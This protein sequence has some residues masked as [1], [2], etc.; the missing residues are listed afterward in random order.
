MKDYTR[1]RI[2]HYGYKGP[3]VPNDDE[4]PDSGDGQKMLSGVAKSTGGNVIDMSAADNASCIPGLP[5]RWADI[6]ADVRDIEKEVEQ[7][8][9]VLSELQRKHLGVQFSA[10]RNE[11]EEERDIEIKTSQIAKLFK[12]MEGLILMLEKELKEDKRFGMDQQRRM[13]DNMKTGMVLGANALSRKFRD[14]QRVYLGRLT[15][16]KEKKSR[17]QTVTAGGTK[18]RDLDR[19][20]VIDKYLEKG[21]TPDQI[22]MMIVNERNTQERDSELKNILTSIVELHEMFRDM[23]TLVIEQG[24]VLDRIDYN[25]TVAREKITKGV[26]EVSTAKKYQD[27]TKFKLCFLLLCVCILGFTIALFVKM[28]TP[29]P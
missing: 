11:E 27:Q 1:L 23:N 10:G 26:D 29:D 18:A 4:E 21:L 3:N 16:Q 17:F 13:V 19:E 20:E 25:L 5:Q 2:A 7:K 24:T 8:I 28:S 15:K 9:A 14:G 6:V 22:E 12:E